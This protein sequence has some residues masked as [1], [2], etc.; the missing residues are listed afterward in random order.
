MLYRNHKMYEAK[1]K[2]EI[3]WKRHPDIGAV[4]GVPAVGL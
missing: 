3:L 1:V 2:E 4:T